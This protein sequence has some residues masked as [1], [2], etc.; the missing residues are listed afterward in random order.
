MTWCPLPAG[1]Q[2]P[3]GQAAPHECRCPC[4]YQREA[5]LGP[6]T[7]WPQLQKHGRVSSVRVR[8]ECC[9][10]SHQDWDGARGSHSDETQW[11]PLVALMSVTAQPASCHPT[12]GAEPE[13]VTFC[14]GCGV[15]G[16][17]RSP[18]APVPWAVGSVGSGASPDLP[19]MPRPTPA[20]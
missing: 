11:S 10:Q 4:G 7:R 14:A 12:A 3:R 2:A 8:C 19:A 20:L 5:D 17:H 15:P 9:L 18:A 13:K 6:R 16:V 1:P